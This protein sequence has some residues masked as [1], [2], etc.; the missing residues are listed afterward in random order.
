MIKNNKKYCYR[1][2]DFYDEA[3]MGFL[4]VKNKDDN[5]DNMLYPFELIYKKLENL[6]K[7]IKE[8]KIEVEK[9]KKKPRKV[10]GGL[11]M[12]IR[13]SRRS[14][15]KKEFWSTEIEEGMNLDY[16]Y[17]IKQYLEIFKDN[18]EKLYKIMVMPAF[19][20]IKNKKW[21]LTSWLPV[22]FNITD[23]ELAKIAVMSTQTQVD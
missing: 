20:D 1:E 21:F 9:D 18:K 11:V 19:Y 23:E 13:F 22:H 7:K 5:G 4:F 12:K 14:P 2:V 10:Y 6:K 3:Y 15:L 8:L 17:K 16:F